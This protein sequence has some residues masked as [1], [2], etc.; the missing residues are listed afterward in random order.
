DALEAPFEADANRAVDFGGGAFMRRAIAGA[1]DDAEDFLRIGQGDDEGM[2]PP[3]AIVGDIH[4]LFAF[5]GG[6]DEDAVHVDPGQ[7]EEAGRLPRPDAFADIVDDVDERVDVR[8]GEPP[9][10]IAG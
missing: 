10:E 3:S 9:A 6:L 8:G 2:I 1:I 7:L 4:A 5:A